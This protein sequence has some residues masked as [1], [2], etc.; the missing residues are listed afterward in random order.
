MILFSEQFSIVHSRRKPTNFG[1]HPFRRQP[2]WRHLNRRWE[3][4]TNV[5]LTDTRF[6]AI[7]FADTN[8]AERT[9]CRRLN[10]FI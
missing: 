6:T 8:F 4:L 10:N 5:C 2:L 1:V 3:N 9:D 7:Y